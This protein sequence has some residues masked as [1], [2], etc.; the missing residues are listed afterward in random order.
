M[1]WKANA[2]VTSTNGQGGVVLAAWDAD[3]TSDGDDQVTAVTIEL[4]GPSSHLKVG[5]KVQITAN[6]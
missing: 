5:D 6:C 3:V 1:G 2:T 4:S